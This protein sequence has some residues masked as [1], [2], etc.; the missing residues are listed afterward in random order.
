MI[1]HCLPNSFT[2][3]V[4]SRDSSK[5]RNERQL[6]AELQ[7]D[8]MEQQSAAPRK[9]P[10]NQETPA[11]GSSRASCLSGFPQPPQKE[12]ACPH[13]PAGSLFPHSEPRGSTVPSRHESCWGRS[14]Q[15]G[16]GTTRAEQAHPCR[17][18]LHKKQ[19]L[20]APLV[21]RGVFE[22]AG[23]WLTCAYRACYESDKVPSARQ[24]LCFG[25]T[26]MISWSPLYFSL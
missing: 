7:R 12:V 19:R 8:G 2:W 10:F 11:E 16:P 14:W 24:S 4:H 13:G 1:S 18:R 3:P 26:S 5:R 9:V 15:L 25:R 17:T 23:C 22:T 21:S 20:R 6:R